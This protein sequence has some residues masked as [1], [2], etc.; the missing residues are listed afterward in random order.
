MEQTVLLVDDDERVLH[1][2]AR[3]LREQ[4]YK[5]YTARSGE[6]AMM[7][8]KTR[9]INVIVVDEK[10]PGVLG[11][12]LLVWV[13]KHYPNVTGIMLTGHA[14]TANA[15]RAINEGA[16]YQYLTK[17]YDSLQLAVAIRKALEHNDQLRE[18]LRVLARA[19]GELEALEGFRR[20][21][22]VLT[23][24]ISR[25]LREPLR[26]IRD[27]FQ[28][29]EERYE[30][31]LDPKARG[32]VDDALSAADEVRQL[33]STLIEHFNTEDP[34]RAAGSPS[35]RRAEESAAFDA[36]NQ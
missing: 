6:E 2:L 24:V 19:K 11:T 12:D 17:P 18:S 22:E 31:I 30:D 5:L 32:L 21:L 26:S 10:M 23:G 33:M 27:S 20:E 9:D 8:L 36:P 7:A 25:D 16:V 3:L 4:P 35:A 1:G 13:A 15:I 28:S 14:S 34:A 29:L